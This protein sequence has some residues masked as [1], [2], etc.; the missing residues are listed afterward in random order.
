MNIQ[1]RSFLPAVPVIFEIRRNSSAQMPPSPGSVLQRV[2]ALNILPQRLNLKNKSLPIT[3]CSI[4][5]RPT[6]NHL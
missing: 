1:S 5:A 4:P 6:Q 2:P 3:T